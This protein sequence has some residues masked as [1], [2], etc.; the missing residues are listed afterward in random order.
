[1]DFLDKIFVGIILSFTFTALFFLMYFNLIILIVLYISAVIFF[2]FGGDLL[3][4]LYKPNV[5][6][7]AYYCLKCDSEVEVKLL[8]YICPN[9]GKKKVA[10][11]RGEGAQ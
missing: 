4:R 3:E 11:Y 7:M 2:A 8:N 6:G 1:M 10:H 9:C 5:S